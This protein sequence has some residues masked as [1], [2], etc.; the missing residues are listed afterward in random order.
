MGSFHLIPPPELV[1]E[2]EGWKSLMPAAL[3]IAHGFS[4]DFSLL[5]VFV[6]L[7]PLPLG[8]QPALEVHGPLV[9][10]LRVKH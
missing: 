2:I 6:R 3:P 4:G 7:E 8:E 1:V 5:R 10:G 9:H